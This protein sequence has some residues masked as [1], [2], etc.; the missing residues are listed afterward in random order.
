MSISGST[1]GISGNIGNNNSSDIPLGLFGDG[2]VSAPSISFQ[3]ESNSGIY[4]VSNGD[5]GISIGGNKIVDVTSSGITATNLTSGTYTPTLTPIL[6]VNTT[7]AYVWAYHRIGNIVMVCGQADFTGLAANTISRFSFTL[8]IAPTTVFA[9]SQRLYGAASLDDT[10]SGSLTSCSV[11]AV[12][13]SGTTGFF[14]VL[15][16]AAFIGG[17]SVNASFMYSIV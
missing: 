17:N 6:G 1:G 7:T 4:R 5:I 2:T 13:P 12:T 3:N 9:T 15:K 11:A 16:D 14:T 10:S 8:P